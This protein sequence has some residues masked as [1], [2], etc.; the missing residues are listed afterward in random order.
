MYGLVKISI[1]Q[2]SLPSGRVIIQRV[3]RTGYRV[4]LRRG[5]KS[6]MVRRLRDAAELAREIM[7]PW[8]FPV[9]K[10]F[11]PVADL[12]RFL[13]RRENRPAP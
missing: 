7:S 11:D 13:D 12:P 2:W 10:K 8:P 4:I 9:E 1:G 3:G 6:Q 5:A